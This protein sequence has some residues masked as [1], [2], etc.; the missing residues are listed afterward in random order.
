VP[1]TSDAFGYV[2][3]FDVIPKGLP[4]RRHKKTAPSA[5]P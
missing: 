1:I 3:V 5:F 2:H 4:P